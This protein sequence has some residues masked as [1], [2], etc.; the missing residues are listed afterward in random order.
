MSRILMYEPPDTGD[1]SAAFAAREH[2]VV[3][4]RDREGL[5]GALGEQRPDLLVYVL[6]DLGVDLG[7]LSLLRR[8]AP[9][10]PLILLGGPAELEARRTVQELRPTYYGVFPLEPEE[11][12]GAIAG[13]LHHHGQRRAAP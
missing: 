4:C 9:A 5:F 8:M 3:V 12:A 2:D 1:P 11:L 10:L 7:V 13:A 6:A